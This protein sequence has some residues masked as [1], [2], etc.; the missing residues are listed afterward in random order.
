MGE[1][2]FKALRA[3]EAQLNN[4]NNTQNAQHEQRLKEFDVMRDTNQK[5]LEIMRQKLYVEVE[6]FRMAHHGEIRRGIEVAL[7]LAVR[8]L[9]WWKRGLKNVKARTAE[10]M[11]EVREMVS[12]E[13]ARVNAEVEAEAERTRVRDEKARLQAEHDKIMYNAI[14]A[15]D[16]A[17]DPVD[18][19]YGAPMEEVKE[20]VNDRRDAM[21]KETEAQIRQIGIDGLVE[22]QKIDRDLMDEPKQEEAHHEI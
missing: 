7:D 10:Y 8:S 19:G 3:I 16:V 14:R 4:R 5:E 15:G 1:P 9:P 12:A 20:E 22:Q 18:D 2:T 11:T 6:Q 21:N 17:V 13:A